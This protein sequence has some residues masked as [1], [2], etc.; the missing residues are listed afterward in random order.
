[1]R[2]QQLSLAAWRLR[3]LTSCNIHLGKQPRKM[4]GVGCRKLKCTHSDVQAYEHTLSMLMPTHGS[5][6]MYI[7]T[8]PFHTTVAERRN[9]AAA[10]A[11]CTHACAHLRNS[12]RWLGFVQ[13]ETSQGER[14]WSHWCNWPA[15]SPVHHGVP[16][17]LP[18][19]MSPAGPQGHHEAG[20]AP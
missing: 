9:M 15:L 4:G 13:K 18:Y 12:S 19:Y 10:D 3:L 11:I 17:Q 20:F 1:M 8:T 2:G 5:T 7:H 16:G 6:H 14:G